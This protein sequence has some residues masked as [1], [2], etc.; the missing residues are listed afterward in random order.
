V[1]VLATAALVLAR[2]RAPVAGLEAHGGG[3]SRRIWRTLAGCGAAV[4]LAGAL[5]QAVSFHPPDSLAGAPQIPARPPGFY[6][7]KWG[8]VALPA[9]LPAGGR[10]RLLVSFETAGTETWPDPRMVDPSGR[11]A[12]GAVRLG[13]RWLDARGL[14]VSDYQSR[15][16]LP[17]PL[18]PGE[19]ITLPVEATLP[20]APGRYRLQVDLVH[21]LVTWFEERGAERFELPVTVQPVPR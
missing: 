7:V 14:V 1:A 16:D 4:L 21:E 6:R 2:D 17:R 12:R 3:T 10:A 13:Y 9:V 11:G 8:G 20:A 15:S 19:S 5:A 18:R